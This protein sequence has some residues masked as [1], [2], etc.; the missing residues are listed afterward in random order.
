ML[1]TPSLAEFSR[2]E[3]FGER[4]RYRSGEHVTL[5]GPTGS[6]KTHLLGDLAKHTASKA[7]RAILL[8][9]KPRDDTVDAIAKR[10]NLAVTHDWPPSRGQRIIHDDKPGW[11]VW[12][13]FSFDP[14][15]DRR[16]VHEIHRRVLLDSYRRGNRLLIVDEA[17]LLTNIYDLEDELVEL[18]TSGRSM[19]AAVWGATQRPAYVPLWMYDQADHLFLANEPDARA[20][21]RYDE[22]G[23]IDRH[24]VE[25]LVMNLDEHEFLYIRRDGP[26]IA[27]IL[28]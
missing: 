9:V 20:R 26:R 28:P 25:N 1:R 14:A 8:A 7:N 19:G 17:Y 15:R 11:V 16:K 13:R 27:K 18:W 5:L 21:Q 4:W 22:I 10:L 2:D 12:P 24:L 23:G 6:G 3:F